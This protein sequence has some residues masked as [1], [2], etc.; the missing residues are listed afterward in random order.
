MAE[1][2]IIRHSS[3]RTVTSTVSNR[4]FRES[5]QSTHS[6]L[7]LGSVPVKLHDCNSKSEG[8]NDETERVELDVHCIVLISFE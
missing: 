7:T 2:M 3:Q 6:F 8:R 4:M 5:Q 1:R